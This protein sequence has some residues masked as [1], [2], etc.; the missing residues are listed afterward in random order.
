MYAA[1][2]NRL[3]VRM[4]G[5]EKT[6]SGIILTN[7]QNE[8]AVLRLEVFDA[9]PNERFAGKTIQVERR[10][11]RELSTKGYGS[12]AIEDILAVETVN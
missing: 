11:V 6:E 10:L 8:A 3:I 5:E 2:N 1:V 9:G 7:D 4:P 12:V